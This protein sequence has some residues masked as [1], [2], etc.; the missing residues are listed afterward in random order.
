MYIVTSDEMRR[1]D[2]YA[3]ESL[4]IPSLALMENA[5]RAVA[6]E[7]VQY[8]KI[9]PCRGSGKPWLI[10]VGKGNNGGDGMVCAR[11]LQEFG[12]EA[13][14]LFASDPGQL[15]GDAAVQYASICKMGFVH[16]VY[17]PGQVSW[18]RYGGIVDALLGTGALG[19]PRSP[20]AALI[21]EA[22]DSGL[23]IVATDIPSG[24]DADTGQTHDPCIQAT[25]TVALAYTKCGLLQYPGAEL[26]GRVVTRKIGIPERLAAQLDLNTFEGNERLFTERFGLT[27]P[28]IRKADAHKGTFGHVLVAAGTRQFSG[29]GLLTAKAALRSGAGLVSWALPERLHDAMLGHL[30]EAMLLAVSDDGRGDWSATS[31]HEVLQLAEGKDALAIGPGMSRFAGDGNWLRQIWSDAACPI[32]V[33]ADALNMLAEA[34]GPGGTWPRRIHSPAILTPHPGEMARLTGLSIREA[35]QDR[36]GLA[37]R[38]AVQHGVV[39]VL[40]GART[41]TATPDGT[42][43]V[44]TTG[45]PGM[46]TGGSGDV[47]SGIIAGLLAQG[48]SPGLAAALGVYTH[49]KAGDHAA[50]NRAA[51]HSL[52]AGDI[53]QSL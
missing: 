16:E 27:L 51:P 11:H 21:R 15:T 17:S 7:V 12:V 35:Q 10:L 19:A 14:L 50:A 36:I 34:G 38:Y 4:D 37:R 30:P 5:G 46:A 52:I 42:T 47:L 6:E 39:L 49:G 40:K 41:V 20:Y 28:P 24:L 22:N 53:V 9:A 26:A 13:T 25:I 48:H 33:D 43:I 45:H 44:N 31:P 3:I 2:R 8:M 1:L 18:D 29:A 32:V 23:P